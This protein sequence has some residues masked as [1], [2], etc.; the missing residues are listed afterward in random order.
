MRSFTLTAVA[1]LLAIASA[2]P[3]EKRVLVVETVTDLVVQTID[4]TTTLYVKPSDAAAHL[5]QHVNN[6]VHPRPTSAPAVP[7]Q[8]IPKVNQAPSQQQAPP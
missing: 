2:V 1:S 7:P 3:L 8:N 5:S 6:P 4:I